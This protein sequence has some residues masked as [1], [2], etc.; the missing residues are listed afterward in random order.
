MALRLHVCACGHP[1]MLETGAINRAIRQG[2]PIYCTRECAGLAR[3]LQNPP[4]EAERKAAKAVYDREF[5]SRHGKRE[6]KKAQNRAWHLA[7][8]DPE[9]ARIERAANMARHVQ[10]CRRPEYVAK[11]REYD[12]EYRAKQDFGEFWESAMLLTDLQSEVLSRATR[13]EIDLMDGTLNKKQQRRRDYE[14][15]IRG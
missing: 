11:K 7:N 8:Y 13:Y 14:R 9:A 15:L 10:Y 2:A 6:R 12:R 4:T 1:A 5:R 3:R